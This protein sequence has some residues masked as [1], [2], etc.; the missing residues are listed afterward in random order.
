MSQRDLP[1]QNRFTGKV[2]H[3]GVSMNA[4]TLGRSINEEPLNIEI[5]QI[6]PPT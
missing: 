5:K 1:Q 2:N 4:A 6:N 3:R